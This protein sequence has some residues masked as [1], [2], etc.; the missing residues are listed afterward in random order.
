M[1]GNNITSGVLGALGRQH[2]LH[3]LA[4]PPSDKAKHADL[5]LSWVV[6]RGATKDVA[7]P[8]KELVNRETS[9]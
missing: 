1:S 3:R 5:Y 2:I 8:Q 6:I 4:E 9:D 7:N